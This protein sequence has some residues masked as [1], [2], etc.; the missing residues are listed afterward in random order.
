MPILSQQSRAARG[1]LDWTQADLANAA[2]LG[3]ATIKNFESGRRE[4]TLANQNAIRRALEDAGIEFI[5]AR[6]G[7]GVGVR[8]RE[9]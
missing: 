3:L 2:T 8:L 5:A 1:L 9:E 4:T 6:G 7:K